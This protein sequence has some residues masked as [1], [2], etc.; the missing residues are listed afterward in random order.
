MI[1]QI[2]ISCTIL[3][4]LSCEEEIVY[5][6]ETTHF[7]SDDFQECEYEQCPE[8]ILNYPIFS[9]PEQLDSIVNNTITEFLIERLIFQGQNISSVKGAVEIYLSNAQ[10]AYPES[11]VSSVVHELQIDIEI[12]YSSNDILSLHCDSYE[13]AG[14]AH[15]IGAVR[16]WNYNPKTSRPLENEALFKDV[17]EF[18]AF[19]KAKF[20]QT[21]G[22]LKQ[23]SFDD[24]N[25][26]LPDNIG[27]DQEGIILFYNVYEIASYA[28][29]TL[30]LRFSWVE[31][32]DYLSF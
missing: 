17:A 10:N 1:K 26:N 16:F 32:E 2:L 14:G 28:D 22:S 30:E 3:L 23:F 9:S 11:S 7:S 6:V 19:A 18:H 5:T 20:I 24:D 21:H 25:Y 31:I 27:F 29:G 12:G 13:F 4:C 8:L 15:G